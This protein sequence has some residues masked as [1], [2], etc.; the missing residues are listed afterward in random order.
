MHISLNWLKDY[1][2]IPKKH[3]AADLAKLITLRSC[4]VEGVIEQKLRFDKIVTAKI[5]KIDPHPDAD[6]LRLPTV[7]I[8]KQEF[9]IVCGAPNIEV[10]QV[11]PLA[12]EGAKV[13]LDGDE[14]EIKKT[15]IRG[16]ESSG[17]LCSARELGFGDDHTGILILPD[18]TKVG[19]ALTEVMGL[20]DIILEIDNKSLTHRPDLW[21]H[22]GMAR[23]VSAILNT[24]FVQPKTPEIAVKEEENFEV[25]VEDPDLC[26]R[27]MGLVMQGVEIKDSPNWMQT[28]LRAAGLRAINNIVDITNYVMLELGQPL[29]AF[30]LKKIP[31]KKIVVRRA[32]KGE[33]ITTLDDEERELSTENLLITNGEKPIAIAGVMGGENTEIDETTKAVFL[34]SANFEAS[35]NRRTS[36]ALGLRTESVMRYEKSLDP[37]LSEASLKRMVALIKESCPKAYV[38]S[39]VYD[40]CAWREPKITLKVN[41]KD[42]SCQA[43]IEIDKKEVKDILTRL[44]FEVDSK[45]NVKV[46]SWR[47]TKDV[48]LPVDLVE[49]VVRIHGYENIPYTLPKTEDEPP[50]VNALWNLERRLKKTI[51]FSCALYEVIN[52]SFV[53]EELLRKFGI[54]PDTCVKLANPLASDQTMLRPDLL[55]NLLLCAQRNARFQDEVRIFEYGSV[56]LKEVGE[57]A[58]DAEGKKKLPRQEKHLCAVLTDDFYAAKKVLE[59]IFAALGLKATYETAKDSNTSTFARAKI[60]KVEVARIATLTKKLTDRFDLPETSCFDLEV[61]KLLDLLPKTMRFRELPKFPAVKRDVAAL[62]TED[63]EAATVL[64]ELKSLSPLIAEIKLFDVYRGEGVPED[65]KSLAFN[66]VYQDPGKTLEEAEIASVHEKVIKKVKEL[67]GEIRA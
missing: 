61:E 23:E 45:L 50:A 38:A 7:S 64:K 20:D 32:K 17:M 15:K 28:R 39:R 25:K 29:H 35:N 53:G 21:G 26:P 24:K 5:T 12:L 9:R 52:F 30:D 36:A 19:K 4:E 51:A 60:G 55:P 56:F 62:F 59:T 8:G 47:A 49:E 31:N 63:I 14:F 46:P 54:N 40:V 18:N 42:I 43:G 22:V 3:S 65:K 27:Y 41:A 1:V 2:E 44:G 10:G 57:L 58:A 11:V 6:K 37:A 33:K 34:E 66:L 16:V 48:S 13:L 67:G